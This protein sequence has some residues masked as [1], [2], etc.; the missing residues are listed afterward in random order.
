MVYTHIMSV[1]ISPNV[2]K[3]SER[4]DSSG[5]IVNPRTKEVIRGA[6]EGSYQP[7]QEELNQAKPQEVS[8]NPLAQAIKKQVKAAVDDAIRGIDIAGM[9][10]KAIEESFK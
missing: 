3:T 4:M 1:I 10:K 6:D 2:K 8:E 5:N 9:V 7:T